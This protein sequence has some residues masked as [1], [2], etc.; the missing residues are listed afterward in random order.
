[1]ADHTDDVVFV[2]EP[3]RPESFV[4]KGLPYIKAEGATWVSKAILYIFGGTVALVLLSGFTVIIVGVNLRGSLSGTDALNPQT[5]VKEA[6]LPFTQGVATFASTVFGPLLAFI[7]GYYFAE[8]SKE[9][10]P[11][12]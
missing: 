1:M 8:K 7:L 2:E 10:R 9:D 11:G 12:S 5:L 6:I 3:P 4:K